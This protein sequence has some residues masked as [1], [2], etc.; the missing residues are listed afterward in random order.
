MTHEFHPL[1]GRT[2]PRFSGIKTFMRLPFHENSQDVDAMIIGVPF[3]SLTS[4][5]P[6]ARFGPSAVREA[7]SLGRAFHWEH[8][9]SLFDSLKVCDGGD[10]FVNPYRDDEAFLAIQERFSAIVQGSCVPLA[11]GGDHSITLP[12]LR[13]LKGYYNEPLALVHFDAHADTYGPAWGVD[14]HHGTF[15]RHA[16]DEGLIHPQKTYQIGLRGGL[17]TGDD[18]AYGAQQGI[19]VLRAQ[20]L[21]TQ[22]WDQTVQQLETFKNEI[23][24][25]PVYLSF[26]VDAM[27]PAFAPGTGTPVP[28]GLSSWQ[29]IALIQQLKGLRIVGA[30]VVEVTPAYDQSQITSILAMSL[31]FE[32]LGLLKKVP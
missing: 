19:K 5:R 21:H 6:G 16:I 18:F 3:D 13:A 22:S 25:Q 4:F 2:S 1:P 23:G 26:D 28:G 17:A 27:D 29:A 9:I 15:V 31:L 11:V 30:D 32:M 12:I 24:K 14:I 20:K 10:V 8:Q 7:T